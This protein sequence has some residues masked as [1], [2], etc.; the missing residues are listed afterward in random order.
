M[1]KTFCG[2]H[3]GIHIWPDV[4][5]F[6]GYRSKCPEIQ[7]KWA[8]IGKLTKPRATDIKDVISVSANSF[9]QEVMW[10]LMW[11]SQHQACVTMVDL[12]VDSNRDTIAWLLLS[13]ANIKLHPLSGQDKI[14]EIVKSLARREV[15]Q[16]MFGRQELNLSSRE[17][18]S[19]SGK[20]PV[21]VLLLQHQQSVIIAASSS[22]T[23]WHSQPPVAFSYSTCCRFGSVLAC[24]SLYVNSIV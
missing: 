14:C 24:L 3:Y 8:V 20:W 9:L 19:L 10:L 13:H 4:D 15:T 12:E 23:G 17:T 22:D 2:T 16:G 6:I 21:R 5:K 1:A 18:R 7:T 11:D